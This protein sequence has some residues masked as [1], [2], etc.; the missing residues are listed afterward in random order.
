MASANVSGQPNVSA[1]FDIEAPEAPHRL[2]M[3]TNGSTSSEV[4]SHILISDA[5]LIIGGV[6]TC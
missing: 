3:S 6:V 5:W 4:L 2:M 1:A